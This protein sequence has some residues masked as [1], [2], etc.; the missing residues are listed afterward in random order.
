MT[1]LHG[2]STESHGNSTEMVNRQS[3]STWVRKDRFRTAKKQV[4]AV[5]NCKVS[6]PGA[7]AIM[8]VAAV[9]VSTLRG[10]DASSQ[11]LT[12]E[13]VSG[14][15][16]WIDPKIRDVNVNRRSSVGGLT[17]KVWFDKQF[18]GTGDAYRRRA[19][20]FSNAERRALRSRIVKGLQTLSEASHAVAS[21]AL[22]SLESD[23][24][25]R[26]LQR[27]WIVNGFTCK[28][29]IDGVE[30]IKT[31]PGV[32]KI[33]LANNSVLRR[34]GLQAAIPPTTASSSD[35]RQSYKHPWYIRSLRA[36]RV[37]EEF[38]IL[39]SGTL[40]VIADGNFAVSPN[41]A[42][43]VYRNPK[44]IPDNGKDDDGNGWIDDCHGYN[45][46]NRSNQLT[47][48]Q[49][50]RAV[51]SRT[52]HGSMCATIICG[53]GTRE[54]PYEFGIAPEAKWAG[55]IGGLFELEPAV[56]W[57]V[58][59]NADTYS[60]SF[61]N[62]NLGEYRSHVRKVFEHGA[63]CGV[64]FV[65]GAGNFAQ[66]AK[67]PMQMRSPEDTPEVVFAAAGVQRDLSK[68]IFSSQGPVR[69]DTE[70]YQDGMVRKPEVCAFNQDL[71]CQLP[72]G[73]VIDVQISG[74][75]FAGPMFCGSIA[76]MLAADPDLLPWDCREI[77][78]Q[79]ATDIADEGYDYQTG[80]GLIDC[81]RAVKEV[82]RRKAV[83]DG[84]D[85]SMY[86]ASDSKNKVDDQLAAMSK[87]KPVLTV[88]AVRPG[89]PAAADG[90]KPGDLVVSING[91]PI[92]ERKGYDSARQRARSNPITLVLQRGGNRKSY[93]VPPIAWGLSLGMRA[94]NVFD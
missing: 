12:M 93:Q 85:A 89:S 18:L 90:V 57:A 58:L 64:F 50:P 10:E 74:N 15:G 30:K 34:G 43:S 49:S 7:L 32:K 38:G 45:F 60:M 2:N 51:F 36:D 16:V 9:W 1:E 47:V 46:V 41:L 20:E 92:A 94:A 27:H 19:E 91:Q 29:T 79:T 23:G 68:T 84:T 14:E 13:T 71:P 87:I 33:F 21:D 82:L 65:S 48:V 53:N 8:L 59:Q 75:S 54:S 63:F 62:P 66:T 4:L 42:A 78:T 70:H 56:E 44:E 76:L 72:N 69:W 39:G 73:D 88:V 55:V 22:Q 52:L 67:L 25:I 17:I 37:W 28:T 6:T 11:Q 3:Q 86:A 24:V 40:N 35:Q 81:Y 31:V 80:H 5:R 26:E 61:S 83:R 77:I